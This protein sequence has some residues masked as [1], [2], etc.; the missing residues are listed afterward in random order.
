MKEGLTIVE[1]DVER[2]NV[3][4]PKRCVVEATTF[5][6]PNKVEIDELVSELE[7]VVKAWL[8]VLAG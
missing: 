5:V 7:P 1:V 2:A 4:M 8:V 3:L 6:G